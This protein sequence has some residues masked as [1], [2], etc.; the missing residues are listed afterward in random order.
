M[1]SNTPSAPQSSGISTSHCVK[2]SVKSG[3][4]G[5]CLHKDVISSIWEKAEKLLNMERGQQRAASSDESAWSVQSFSSPTPHFVTS[6]SNGQFLCDQQ[7][8]QWVGVNICSHT[9]QQSW[10]TV[11]FLGLVQQ[12][13]L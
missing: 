2:L 10:K 9:S 7:C 3:D 11:P 8:C 4:S 5:L 13:M 1:F 6:K 12:G